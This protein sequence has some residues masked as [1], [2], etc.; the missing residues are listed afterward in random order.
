MISFRFL[1]YFCK[2]SISYCSCF[3]HIKPPLPKQYTLPIS[4]SHISSSVIFVIS[5][6]TY[7]FN[8]FKP[9]NTF[10][11]SVC[12]VSAFLLEYSPIWDFLNVK[13]AVFSFYCKHCITLYPQ[14]H[15]SAFPYH[16]SILYLGKTLFLLLRY[17][18]SGSI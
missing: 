10:P 12:V 17:Y 4:S 18:F 8:I 6:L 13:F 9:E 1:Y 2:A 14:I 15:S 7:K 16:A 5:S 11:H 3:I